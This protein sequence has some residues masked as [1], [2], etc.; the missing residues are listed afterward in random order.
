MLMLT[1]FNEDRHHQRHEGVERDMADL[2]DGPA[3]TERKANP[4]S[5][6]GLFCSDS[7]SI[8]E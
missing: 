5:P 1:H 7:T 8:Y 6:R 4:E 3:G 2:D